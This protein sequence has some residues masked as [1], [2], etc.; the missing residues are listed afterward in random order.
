MDGSIQKRKDRPARPYRAR[1]SGPD[2]KQRSKSFAKKG[3][4]E[5]WLRRE[6]GKL[7]SGDWLD[8][9]SGQ[10]TLRDWSEIWLHG[11]TDPKAKTLA[12]Y[13]S[14]LRSRVL[15]EF[16][17]HQLRQVTPAAVRAW[18]AEMSKEGLSPA[19]IRQARQVLHQMFEQAVDDGLVARNP[20]TRVKAPT[21]RPR[22]QLFLSAEEVSRLADACEKRQDGAGVLVR[23]LSYSGLRWGEAVAL[24]RSSITRKGCHVRVKEAATEIGGKLDFGT[25]KTHEARTVIL[26]A[27]VADRLE[28]HI[29]GMPKDGLVF[30]AP[31]GGPLRTSNFRRSVW[32]DACEEADMPDGLLIHD[33]RDTAASLMISSGASIK[34]VQ[35]ALGHASAAMTLNVYGGLFEEDL[36]DLASRLDE[37]FA[38]ADQTPTRPDDQNVAYLPR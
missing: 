19:R 29:E 21:V 14:L 13:E 6:L 12:G 8:P 32:T 31:Q 30:T 16:G 27:F 36:E 24:K 3:D 38:A 11:L 1:Y 5:R 23:F 34:A 7:D 10:I 17:D 18:M 15:P 35:R 22:R 20:T 28:S 37:R 2:G 25:P 9:K 33:L 4:A 26:P